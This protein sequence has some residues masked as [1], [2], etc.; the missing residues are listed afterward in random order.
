MPL[1]HPLTGW[2][3]ELLVLVLISGGT[4]SLTPGTNSLTPGTTPWDKTAAKTWTK[5]THD[6]TPGAILPSQ[7][8]DGW[9]MGQD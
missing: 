6:W 5:T 1:S 4:N 9:T 8:H 3:L 2:D 7:K